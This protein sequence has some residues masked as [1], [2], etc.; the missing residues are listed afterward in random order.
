MPHCQNTRCVSKRLH[1]DAG[2][3]IGMILFVIALLAV[4]GIAM[5]ASGNFMGT[6][7]TPDRIMADL[8]AQ[9]NLIRS[10]ILECNQYSFER[11]EL[12]DKY[13][14]SSG[15]GTLVE[16]LDCNAFV[17]EGTSLP[18]PMTNLWSGAHPA[19]L[20]PPT[21]GFDKWYYVN[22]GASGG[23]C[24]RI[25]PLAGFVNDLG[26]KNGLVQTAT[27]F[28]SQEVVFDPNSSSLRFILWITK[29]TGTVSAD[30][31]S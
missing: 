4:I 6:T 13:P 2:I 20:P 29:P 28:S 22:A 24:I 31:S 23:R 8:K 9:A 25:Q 16:S 18:S 19:T 26:V 12:A 27:F 14:S 3:A 15:N 21:T 11:G 1:P 7:V 10:K 30:C 5:G 17:A